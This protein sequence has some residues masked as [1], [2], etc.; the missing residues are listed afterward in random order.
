MTIL[1]YRI[2]QIGGLHV[3]R[4]CLAA[5]SVAT[6]A[7]L[8]GLYAI[9]KTWGRDIHWMLIGVMIAMV[10][11]LLISGAGTAIIAV[12]MDIHW[13]WYILFLGVYYAIFLILD[14]WLALWILKYTEKR[15]QEPDVDGNFWNMLS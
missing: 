13:S 14:T 6:V 5:A 12:F 7:G 1:I 8:L 10:I 4:A 9:G 15:E 3:S 2:S 11:R